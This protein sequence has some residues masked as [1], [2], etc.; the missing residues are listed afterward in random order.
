MTTKPDLIPSQIDYQALLAKYPEMM[1]LSDVADFLNCCAATVRKMTTDGVLAFH[2]YGHVIRVYKQS[3]IN[4]LKETSC[5][6]HA[7]QQGSS[8]LKATQSGISETE[9]SEQLMAVASNF[10][11]KQK[12]GRK[13]NVR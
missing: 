7:S 8:G 2:K 4:H 1:R 5:H 9:K 10:Q 13:L 11:L 6:A 3:L 12:I